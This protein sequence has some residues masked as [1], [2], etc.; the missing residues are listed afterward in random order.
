M[1]SLVVMT[2]SDAFARDWDIQ[3]STTMM[4]GWLRDTPDMSTDGVSLESRHIGDGRLR[5]RG[6]LGMVG[7]GSDLD[8]T[9]DDRWLVPLGGFNMW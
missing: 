1:L 9:V 3:F 4:G 2:S 8:L 5:S 7:I 6:G